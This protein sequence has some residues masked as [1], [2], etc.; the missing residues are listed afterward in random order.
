MAAL[1]GGAGLDC[2]RAVFQTAG[3]IK[4]EESLSPAQ[5][6]E[7]FGL[8]TETLLVEFRMMVEELEEDASSADSSD[9]SQSSGEDEE[10]LQH[11][12]LLQDVDNVC[13]VCTL[14]TLRENIHT[15][16]HTA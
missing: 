16:I 2:T 13:V 7:M 5:R 6:N 9:S 12:R 15:Y 14:Y 8:Y 3:C 4:M 11:R 1:Q 10:R